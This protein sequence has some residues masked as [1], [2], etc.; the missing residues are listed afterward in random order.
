MFGLIFPGRRLRTHDTGARLRRAF[1]NSRLGEWV[2]RIATTGLPASKRGA[3]PASRH[4]ESALGS[5]TET[6]FAALPSPERAAL[7]DLPQVVER[8]ER[9]AAR[10]REHL[11]RGDD[12]TWADR[13]ERSVAA[14]ETL[15]VGLLRMTVGHVA[16]SSLTAD[17]DAARELSQRID[18]LVA[19]AEEAAEAL[20]DDRRPSQRSAQALPRKSPATTSL[21]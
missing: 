19:G 4:T 16:A 5:A 17:L 20:A 12:G 6:L 13:L 3:W 10:A 7:D 14:I 1:W 11:A 8:L 18:Y 9:E 21:G 2:A 15:R